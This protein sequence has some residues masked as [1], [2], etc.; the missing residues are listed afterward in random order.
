MDENLIITEKEMA[1][2]NMVSKPY[3]SVFHMLFRDKSYL[4]QMYQAL[5]PEDTDTTAD[6]LK[7]LFY[8][9]AIL[10]DFVNDL[11]FSAKDR[12]LILFEAQSTECGNMPLRLLIYLA[13]SLIDYNGENRYN[14]FREAPIKLPK[15]EL[16]VLYTCEVEKRFAEIS[17]AETYYN[18]ENCPVDLMVNVLYGDE[19]RSIIQEYVTFCKVLK[20]QVQ[21]YGAN[22]KAVTETI[23][24]CKNKGVLEEF[25]CKMEQ[26]VARVVVDL[27]N[28][29]YFLRDLKIDAKEEGKDEFKILLK[30]I[31]RGDTDEM[32]LKA[33]YAQEEIDKARRFYEELIA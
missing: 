4:L 11:S 12:I 22:E 17:F 1:N 26:E 25:L 8:N 20:E 6:D 28:E 18:G 7:I 27:F 19:K 16:Y 21:L 33:G 32:L 24:I 15:L 5:H 23:A 13:K 2:A 30:M 29:E 10:K 31:R 3:D 9:K 14:L